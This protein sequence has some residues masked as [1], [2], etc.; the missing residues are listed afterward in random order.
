M[1]EA[2][3]KGCRYSSCC[4]CCQPTGAV[5]AGHAMARASEGRQVVLPLS[6]EVRPSDSTILCLYGVN[7]NQTSP[8]AA[9]TRGSFLSQPASQSQGGH[10]PP[11]RGSTP[12]RQPMVVDLPAP[13]GPSRQKHSP[14]D[15]RGDGREEER[16][17]A[18]QRRKDQITAGRSDLNST[19]TNE[20]GR[21]KLGGTSADLLDPALVLPPAA[22]S[23]SADVKH[24]VRAVGCS[25]NS[26]ASRA[27]SP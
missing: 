27:A 24:G 10:S 16:K 2:K 4:C 13:L 19:L 22:S 20:H 12:V 11:S 7:H 26:Q 5:A 18:G 6:R 8:I 14:A 9:T 1:P 17:G 21:M 23:Q 15:D 3:A 25:T